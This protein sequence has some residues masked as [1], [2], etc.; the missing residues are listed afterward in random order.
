MNN[1]R[2]RPNTGGG[3]GLKVVDTRRIYMFN[4]TEK[5]AAQFQSLCM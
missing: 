1:P 2:E 5:S 3:Q 4:A